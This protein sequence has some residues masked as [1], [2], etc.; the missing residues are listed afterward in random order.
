M[1]TTTPRGI[2]MI[3]ISALTF[4]LAV[5]GGYQ[6]MTFLFGDPAPLAETSEPF[7]RSSVEADPDAE[8]KHSDTR[9]TSRRE[10]SVILPDSKTIST[11]MM[12][13]R[14]MT[15]TCSTMTMTA[16]PSRWMI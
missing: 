2:S 5:F 10:L 11:P 1:K 3:V 7:T 16:R 13:S 14:S 4:G 15:T 12:M 6:L 8:R 9:D